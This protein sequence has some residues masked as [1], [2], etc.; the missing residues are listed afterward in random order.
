L[1]VVAAAAA[2]ATTDA[3][4]DVDADAEAESEATNCDVTDAVLFNNRGLSGTRGAGRI[5]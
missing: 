4:V 3:D 1:L 2:A 5:G